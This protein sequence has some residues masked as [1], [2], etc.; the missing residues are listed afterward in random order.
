MRLAEALRD[1]LGNLML[2]EGV[3][4]NELHLA[5]LR[6]RGVATALVMAEPPAMTEAQRNALLQSVEQRLDYIF[7]L[8][9]DSPINIRLKQ[10]IL[11]YRLEPFQ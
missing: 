2:P 1:R 5:S 8:S 7:R 6:Q 3:C 9:A 4:L 11:S 10:L